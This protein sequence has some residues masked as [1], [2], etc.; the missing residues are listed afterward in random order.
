M[1]AGAVFGGLVLKMALLLN[2]E[3]ILYIISAPLSL[4]LAL[5]NAMWALW[6]SCIAYFS[7]TFILLTSCIVTA[8]NNR[9]NSRLLL[10]II[11]LGLIV[12]H[13]STHQ[14]LMV[15][16]SRGIDRLIDNWTGK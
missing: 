5:T 8:K 4:A 13:I 10:G 7:L 12:L 11:S 6:V 2:Q 9:R 15:R 3:W 16:F 14:M 1:L